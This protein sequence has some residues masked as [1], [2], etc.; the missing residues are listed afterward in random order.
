MSYARK[1]L[2]EPYLSI[3]EIGL[4][5][6]YEEVNY[7]CRIFKKHNRTSPGSFRMRNYKKECHSFKT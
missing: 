1:L 6:G 7:F 4:M 5:C 3:K 2:A